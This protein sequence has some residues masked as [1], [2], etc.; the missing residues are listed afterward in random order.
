MESKLLIVANLLVCMAGGFMCICRMSMMSLS[1]TKA[2]IRWQY[3]FWF[4]TFAASG[5]SWTYDEPASFAQLL[6]SLAIVV[7]L[8]LGLG[9]WRNGAP[10]YTRRLA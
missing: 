6:M 2:E 5:I 7:H 10:A 4:S 9:A 3:V 1:T 8:I